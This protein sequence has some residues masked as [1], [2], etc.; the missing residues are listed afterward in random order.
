MLSIR[1]TKLVD[2]S[3]TL[4]VTLNNSIYVD[5]P[6][7][8]ISFLSI[9]PPPMPGGATRGVPMAEWAAVR[10]TPVPAPHEEEGKS[11]HTQE[12]P[13]PAARASSTTLHPDPSQPLVQPPPPLPAFESHSQCESATSTYTSPSNAASATSLP[14]L[15]TIPAYSRAQAHAQAQSSSPHLSAFSGFS[16]RPETYAYPEDD[17]QLDI[18]DENQDTISRAQ[19]RAK[20]RQRSLMIIRAEMERDDEERKMS[21][22]QGWDADARGGAQT[23]EGTMEGTYETDVDVERTPMPE[24]SAYLPRMDTAPERDMPDVERGIEELLEMEEEGW[25]FDSVDAH[26]PSHQPYQPYTDQNTEMDQNVDPEHPH[27]HQQDYGQGQELELLDEERREIERVIPHPSHELKADDE[28]D[29][30]DEPDR[31]DESHA[32]GYE[33]ELALHSEDE[34][35]K[36]DT[37]TATPRR[38]THS[39]SRALSSVAPASP[40][41]SAP[42]APPA[43]APEII[44]ETKA[45]SEIQE[46][47]EVDEERED[48][49]VETH[50]DP[51]KRRISVRLPPQLLP[52]FSSSTSIPSPSPDSISS[53]APA[54]QRSPTKSPTKTIIRS[55]SVPSLCAKVS[56]E[57]LNE[58]LEGVVKKSGIVSSSSM[59]ATTTAPTTA[60]TGRRVS[61]LSKKESTSS[62]ASVAEVNSGGG[63][64]KVVQKKNSFSFATPG[65]PLKVKIPLSP[66]PNT[67]SPIPSPRKTSRKPSPTKPNSNPTPKPQSNRNRNPSPT[68]SPLVSSRPMERAPSDTSAK[69]QTT[70]GASPHNSQPPPLASP[71]ASDSASSSEGKWLESPRGEEEAQQLHFLAPASGG[72]GYQSFSPLI[73]PT[74]PQ[75]GLEWGLMQQQQQRQGQDQ[76]QEQGLG[77]PFTFHSLRP[78]TDS[79]MSRLSLPRPR[80]PFS[81]VSGHHHHYHHDP[82]AKHDTLPIPFDEIS[83]HASPSSTPSSPSSCHSMLPSVKTKIAQMESREEALRKFSVSGS[84][85]LSP[86]LRLSKTDSERQTVERMEEIREKEGESGWRNDRG[87]ERKP[88]VKRK[89]YTAALAPRANRTGSKAPLSAPRPFIPRQTS[90][91]TIHSTQSISSGSSSNS[92]YDYDPIYAPESN[93]STPKVPKRLPASPSATTPTAS[94]RNSLVH[95]GRLPISPA[96][97]K[98]TTTSYGDLMSTPKLDPFGLGYTSGGMNGVGPGMGMA[99]IGGGL[100]KVDEEVGHEGLSRESSYEVGGYDSGRCE[101]RVRM[102]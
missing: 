68:K 78:P 88:P 92:N 29:E 2:V 12:T 101:A 81:S 89:S 13:I 61:V 9:D 16:P 18:D 3:Y 97:T 72:G 71:R 24:P 80:S 51:V 47:T 60:T 56:R 1:R 35:D 62:L 23:Q 77:S 36:G 26:P 74:S 49:H 76:D 41:V 34:G 100:H 59:S 33:D 4:R 22:A 98:S 38:T 55:G 25:D 64:A 57:A 5:L 31:D 48:R 70:N 84:A 39:R 65:S 15:F 91:S 6:V 28:Q 75:D 63:G 95:N 86:P 20:G 79:V 8:L 40:V 53:A 52:T 94:P 19:N 87:E 10:G 69:S 102:E 93:T 14:N 85:M 32:W 82:M 50:L 27:Q 11:R 99:P 21:F 66:A 7:T 42:P 67:Q 54:A 30:P 45:E 37:P 58:R 17:P 96:S 46:K 73:S 44:M 90:T 83:I 43:L